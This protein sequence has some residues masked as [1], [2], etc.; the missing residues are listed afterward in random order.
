MS[1]AEC[2]ALCCAGSGYRI[3]R[4]GIGIVADENVQRHRLLVKI[5]LEQA[6]SGNRRPHVVVS[7][8]DTFGNDHTLHLTGNLCDGTDKC[9]SDNVRADVL[10]V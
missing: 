4:L 10:N 2:A 6:A 3:N 9:I 8:L 1:H 5:A 7:R